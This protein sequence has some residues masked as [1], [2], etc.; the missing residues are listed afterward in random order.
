MSAG[1]SDEEY[2]TSVVQFGNFNAGDKVQ[3]EF[4]GAWDEFARGNPDGTVPNWEIDAVTVTGQV[5]VVPDLPQPLFVGGE[6]TIGQDVYD[7]IR[8][9]E[10]FGP[11]EEGV[12]GFTGRIVT[13]AEHGVTLNNQTI[14]EDVLADFEGETAIG[15]YRVVDMA[16]SVGTFGENLAY[17]NGINNDSQDDFAVE[18]TADVVIPAGT[19]TIGL[20]SDDGGKIR[21]PG[22]VFDDWQNNDSIEDDEIRFEAPRAHGW[23]VGTFRLNE[24][25]ETTITGQFYERGGGDSF[26]IAVIDE[27]LI[28]N[29]DP[30]NGWELLGDGVF[31]WSVTTTA[32]PLLSADLSAEV[33]VATSK[34]LR[35]DVNG[36]TDEADQ[37]V[38]ENPDPDVYTTILDIDGTTFQIAATGAWRM[39]TSSLSSTPIRFWAHQP[40]R[41]AIQGRRGPLIPKRVKSPWVQYLWVIT[42]TTASWMPVTWTCRRSSFG[43]PVDPAF[44]LNDD[45]VVNYADRE[46]WVNDLK[47]TWIGDA[48]LNGEFNSGDMV[49]VFSRGKYET[50][51]DAPVGK[52][53][54]GTA[55]PC[56]HCRTRCRR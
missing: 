4:L 36:D 17:P 3:I 19:W 56:R 16:G 46:V 7:S 38:V 39:V 33:E 32:E 22:V 31:D 48:N 20:G 43:R 37:L 12:P 11:P 8:S 9:N 24:P 21:I 23:T 5:T 29:A 51:E 10:V 47:N 53:V 27:E 50:G 2:I 30:N 1:Y 55:T 15:T 40:S 54:T 35:F 18:V 25:L 26:E 42:T 49:Q 6:G 44:D 45:G 52:T 41:H 28:E 14:A 34:Y 13:Y